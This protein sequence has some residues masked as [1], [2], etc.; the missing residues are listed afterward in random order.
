MAIP[1]ALMD[2]AQQKDIDALTKRVDDL[3]LRMDNLDEWIKVI[4]EKL[5]RNGIR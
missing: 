3:E 5:K 1:A 4:N 2:W